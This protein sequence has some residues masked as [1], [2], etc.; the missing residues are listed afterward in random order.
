M[1]NGRGRADDD[2]D[3]GDDDGDED[4]AA[5]HD[6]ALLCSG[7][8]WRPRRVCSLFLLLSLCGATV[9]RATP[10]IVLP[11]EPRLSAACC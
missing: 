11:A 4:T 9:L 8:V 7:N 3:D 2:D 6:C 5:N 1:V 10:R